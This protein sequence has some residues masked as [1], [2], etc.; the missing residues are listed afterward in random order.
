[1]EN[2]AP[3]SRLFALLGGTAGMGLDLLT[4]VDWYLNWGRILLFGALPAA[5]L[6]FPVYMT[7]LL[8]GRQRGVRAA[9]VPVGLMLL[10]TLAVA[11]GSRWLADHGELY[12]FIMFFAWGFVVWLWLPVALLAVWLGGWRR[13]VVLARY[14][15]KKTTVAETSGTP[16]SQ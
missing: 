16:G 6:A 10:Y 4:S 1:M 15:A 5:V 3:L 13:R 7:A 8:H 12:T 11:V 2:W 14:W 9:L